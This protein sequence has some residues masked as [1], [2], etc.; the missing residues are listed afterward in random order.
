VKKSI[1]HIIFDLG[2]GGAETMLV[3]VIRELTEYKNIVVTLADTNH[4]EAELQC[5]QLICLNVQSPFDVP[6][7]VFKLKQI[8][9][10]EKPA[11]VHSHLIWPQ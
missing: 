1:I 4:F 8:I 11:F 10:K 7:A 3:K 9:K 6:K 5:D 2:R